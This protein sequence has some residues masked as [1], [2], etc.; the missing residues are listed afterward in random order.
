MNEYKASPFIPP[1]SPLFLLFIIIIIIVVVEGA[2]LKKH[3]ITL[4]L[5][6]HKEIPKKR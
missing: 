5:S 2:K 3:F 4:N 1:H 6:T